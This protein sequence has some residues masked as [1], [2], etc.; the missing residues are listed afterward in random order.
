MKWI[1]PNC[2]E[3][4]PTRHWSVQRHIIRKHYGTGEPISVNTRK[5]RREMNIFPFNYGLSS[6]PSSLNYGRPPSLS[7]PI[8]QK[9]SYEDNFDS[10]LDKMMNW[11][12]RMIRVRI[13][14][15]LIK[16]NNILQ[17]KK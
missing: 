13:L 2:T 8:N 3:L 5:S 12:D 17:Q 14:E 16:L 4:S 7:F 15:E 9:K 1:C 10:F 11:N 6:N